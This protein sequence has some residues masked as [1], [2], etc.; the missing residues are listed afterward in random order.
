MV[1][2]LNEIV[3][4]G[5]NRIKGKK[6]QWRLRWKPRNG[7]KY[8]TEFKGTKAEALRRKAE[9]EDFE[10][11]NSDLSKD[12]GFEEI[13]NIKLSLS[14]TDNPTA[15]GKS[16]AF[17]VKW[18]LKNYQGDE[19]I[20]TLKYY[21]RQYYQIK[22]KATGALKVS[23][24]QLKSEEY[25]IGPKGKA[26]FV[27]LFGEMKPTETSRKEIQEYLDGNSSGWHRGKA[28]KAFFRWMMGK[29]AFHNES[30]CLRINPLDG[31]NFPPKT[32]NHDRAIATNQEV[33]DL[34]RLANTEE[35]NY[36]SARWAFMF[37][38]GMRPSECQ[39]FW[40]PKNKLGWDQIN[41]SDKQP[42]LYIDYSVIRKPG[43]AARK[44]MIRE[45]FLQLLKEFKAKG[46]K[47][48]P[49]ANIKDWKRVHAKLR[50][51]SGDIA[52]RSAQR[53]TKQRISPATHSSVIFI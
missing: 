25:L 46:E 49:L 15:Q 35:F 48:Y 30:P 47:K 44:I 19:E 38:T 39:R 27:N 12:L 52:L 34:L 45:G 2:V 20:Q 13:R 36:S 22:S 9:I 28:L 21:Y 11:G 16:I 5:L 4:V 50:K 40:D 51:K 24:G 10:N 3:K 23:T 53:R 32:Q 1:P 37:F 7:D 29:S 33:C 31:V 43:R 17:A 18:F 42:Y 6:S 41:L 8:I 14:Q 26:S